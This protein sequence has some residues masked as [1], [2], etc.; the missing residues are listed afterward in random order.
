MTCMDDLPPLPKSLS[1][2]NKI[3]IDSDSGLISDIESMNL[4]SPLTRSA[5]QHPIDNHADAGDDNRKHVLSA[6][7]FDYFKKINQYKH[8]RYHKYCQ[9]NN[10]NNNGINAHNQY[11]NN[12][13]NNNNYNENDINND[14]DNNNQKVIDDLNYN[15]RNHNNCKQSHRVIGEKILQSP[16][17][18]TNK[19][20]N[21]LNSAIDD[22]MDDEN[23]NNN[24]ND[25]VNNSNDRQNSNIKSKENIKLDNIQTDNGNNYVNEKLLKRLSLTSNAIQIAGTIS[26][27]PPAIP[28]SCLDNQIATLRKEMVSSDRKR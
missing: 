2:A 22:I 7:N 15:N 19:S 20:M 9:H 14:N 11:S 27:V 18:N 12:N 23:D 16:S 21:T 4:S 13:N 24:I 10:M 26:Q 6:N 28:G 1:E 25:D 5:K 3:F 17:V 8:N